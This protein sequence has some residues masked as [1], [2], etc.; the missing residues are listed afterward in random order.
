M[1]RGTPKGCAA[2][3]FNE[4]A[5]SRK[6][7]KRR[8]SRKDRNFKATFRSIPCLSVVVNLETCVWKLV[9]KEPENLPKTTTHSLP[10]A[11]SPAAVSRAGGH[12]HERPR[13]SEGGSSGSGPTTRCA[14][15]TRPSR[16]FASRH[17]PVTLGACGSLALAHPV[18]ACPSCCISHSGGPR[19]GLSA[20]GDVCSPRWP[21]IFRI[22]TASV[23]KAMTNGNPCGM[24][25]ISP[26]HFEHSRVCSWGCKSAGIWG[27]LTLSQRLRS[28]RMRTPPSRISPRTLNSP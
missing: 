14:D 23:M 2:L 4:S 24:I 10:V 8:M 7:L 9:S 28:A 25:L 11:T 5:L 26:P 13:A 21:R 12:R 27:L 3:F 1:E 16:G 19:A 17:R 18:S 15:R 22:T 6:R 20:G